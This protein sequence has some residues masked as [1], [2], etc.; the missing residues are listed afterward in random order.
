V[1]REELFE[2][3]DAIIDDAEAKYGR[4]FDTARHD[5]IAGV[6]SVRDW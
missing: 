2:A 5:L 4:V 6:E 1:E 3:L